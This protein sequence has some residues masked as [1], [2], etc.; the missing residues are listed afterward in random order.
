MTSRARAEKFGESM[1]QV[2]TFWSICNVVLKCEGVV[3]MTWLQAFAPSL[4]LMVICLA[5]LG[6]CKLVQA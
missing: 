6:L 5:L 2:V 3:E 4:W 1:L